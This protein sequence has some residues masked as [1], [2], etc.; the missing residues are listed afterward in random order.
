MVVKY[1]LEWIKQKVTGYP[2]FKEAHV[3]Y[4]GTRF[5]WNMPASAKSMLYIS[6]PKNFLKSVRK[7]YRKHLDIFYFCLLFK[8]ESEKLIHRAIWSFISD[9]ILRV[10]SHLE[11]YCHYFSLLMVFFNTNHVE[12]YLLTLRH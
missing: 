7:K 12:L 2:Q 8:D 1:W 3:H 11:H 10:L 4:N 9:F 5:L 6:Q